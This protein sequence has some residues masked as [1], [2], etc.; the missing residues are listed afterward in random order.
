MKKAKDV[1]YRIT[2]TAQDTDLKDDD[3]AFVF[4]SQGVI[5]AVQIN[6]DMDDDDELPHDVNK[7][8]EYVSELK[9]L[10]KVG[11]TLH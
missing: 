7:M 5:R 11:R 10:S 8:I 3:F 1:D 2:R 4:N 6:G 9:L